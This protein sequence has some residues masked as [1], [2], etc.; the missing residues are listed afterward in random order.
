MTSWWRACCRGRAEDVGPFA[1]A[2]VRGGAGRE[3]QLKWAGD[4][5]VGQAELAEQHGRAG[6]GEVA[7]D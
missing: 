2:L 5:G 3:G 7:L 1:Q 6:I 4:F